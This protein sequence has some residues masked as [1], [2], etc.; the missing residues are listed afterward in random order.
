MPTDRLTRPLGEP[1]LPLREGDRGERAAGLH[2][3]VIAA[4]LGI[5]STLATAEEPPAVE[6]KTYGSLVDILGIELPYHE[7]ALEELARVFAE[8]TASGAGAHAARKQVRLLNVRAAALQSL[9][10]NLSLKVGRE[11]AER[12]RVAIQEAEAV[13]N[14]VFNVSIGYRQ[15]MSHDRTRHG[16]VFL[17]G[18]TPFAEGKD[19]S[20]DLVG[21]PPT[22]NTLSSVAGTSSDPGDSTFAEGVLIFPTNRNN[23]DRQ[24]DIMSFISTRSQE[25]RNRYCP[26]G[27]IE[28]NICLKPVKASK[29]NLGDPTNTWN[30]DV[31]VQQQLPWGPSYRISTFTTDRDVFYNRRGDSFDRDFATTLLLEA[32][33]PLPGAKDFGPNAPADVDV[34]LRET[35]AERAEWD[36]KSIINAT[37]FDSDVRYWALVRAIENLGLVVEN[38]KLVEQQVERTN[39]LFEQGLTTAYGKA[40]VDAE[41][42]RLRTTEE[43]AKAAVI[44]ASNQLALLLEQS[45]EATDPYLLLPRDYAQLL[46]NLLVL[47]AGDAAAAGL[48]SRPDLAAAKVSKQSSE[49]VLAFAE[50]QL[51]PDLKLSAAVTTK[52]D[53]TTAGYQNYWES[54]RNTIDP[55][56]LT[57]NYTGTYVYPWK[58]RTLKARHTQSEKSD[59]IQAATVSDLENQVVQQVNDALAAVLGARARVEVA[60]KNVEFAQA[61]FDKLVQRRESGGDVR[62]LELITKSQELLAAKRAR[63]NALIDNKIAESQLLAA[64]GIIAGAYGEMTARNDFE[65]QRLDALNRQSPLRFFAQLLGLAEPNKTEALARK[66]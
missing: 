1:P 19:L 44:T 55:D 32:V 16:A 41:L 47:N 63:I 46:D 45:G 64:Q 62:E 42:E 58:N 38:R 37:L 2:L 34:R 25:F 33:F 31:S 50:H 36:L 15:T 12:V 43:R 40:V 49:I 52:Q 65:R 27:F 51:R 20:V 5:W 8:N 35:A 24:V 66:D 18:F 23:P 54:I 7:K 30:Y 61:A 14:P 13:F 28:P 59:Q 6:S 21:I 53:S 26:D 57:Q 22:T 11:E 9:Q 56:T 3:F 60:E 10:K 17:K 48:K 29:N 39:H 4:A